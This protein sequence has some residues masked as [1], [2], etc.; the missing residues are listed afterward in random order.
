M[1]LAG[2]VTCSRV[3]HGQRKLHRPGPLTTEP[4]VCLYYHVRDTAGDI[5]HPA[6]RPAAE[7]LLHEAQTSRSETGNRPFC[8]AA[9]CQP[10]AP[11]PH[12]AL[13][14]EDSDTK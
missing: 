10:L 11:H 4:S 5:G 3:R 8:L 7:L 13:P 9:T 6:P 14:Q 2:T 1:H 12:S